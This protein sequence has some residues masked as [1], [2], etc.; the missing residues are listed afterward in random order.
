[1]GLRNDRYPVLLIHVVGWLNIVVGL[2][3]F[4][5]HFRI[6]L[7]VNAVK[8]LHI[9]KGKHLAHHLEYEGILIE[10]KLLRHPPFRQAIG[11]EGFYVQN[12]NRL[13]KR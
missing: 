4:G 5:A 8:C 12:R 11:S 10:R 13:A 1:M 3:Q 6:D 7:Q 9:R 2:P